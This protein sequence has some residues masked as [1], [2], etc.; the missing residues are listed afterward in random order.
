MKTC[1]DADD[2]YGR[3]QILKNIGISKQDMKKAIHRELGFTYIMPLLL[4]AIS[5]VFIIHAIER[6]MRTKTLLPINLLTLAVVFLFDL[7]LYLISVQMYEKR[8]GLADSIPI[9]LQSC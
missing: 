7:M 2:D 6:V 9:E 1:N 3:C 5:S 4:T 8:C